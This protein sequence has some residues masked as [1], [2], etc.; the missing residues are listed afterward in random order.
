MRSQ[1]FEHWLITNINS[2]VNGNSITSYIKYLNKV[3]ERLGLNIDTRLPQGIEQV[4]S[5]MNEHH[6][7]IHY[8]RKTLQNYS[9]ALRKYNSFLTS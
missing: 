7:M 5:E 9:S 4:I 1:E 6:Q 8:S 3:E 2:R